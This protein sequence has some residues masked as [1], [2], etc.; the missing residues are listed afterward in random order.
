M[1]KIDPRALR[2]LQLQNEMEPA[3]VAYSEPLLALDWGA[4]NC[5]LAWTPDGSVCLPLGVWPTDEVATAIKNFV[6]EKS[7]SELIVGLPVSSDSSEN[8]TC[9][10][11]RNFAQQF[12]TTLT[13]IFSNERGSSQAT[14][15]PDRARIDDLAAA[16]I[17][18]NYLREQKISE[19]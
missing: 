8:D 4:K 1:K 7:I 13:V 16:Q 9:A 5:G 3:P 15:S 2:S 14:L 18:Q 17:L 6:Q 11:V 10:H 19:I 12:S